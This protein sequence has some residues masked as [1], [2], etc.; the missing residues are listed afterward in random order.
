MQRRVAVPVVPVQ[1]GDGHS[2]AG[3][4]SLRETSSLKKGTDK[5]GLRSSNSG[6]QRCGG[7]AIE[8][9][10]WRRAQE[11]SSLGVASESRRRAQSQ[12]WRSQPL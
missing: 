6:G 5:A 1:F 9:A 3:G 7:V 10:G 12:A 8:Q 2:S 4:C 11:V